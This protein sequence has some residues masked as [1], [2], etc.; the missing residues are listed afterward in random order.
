M[1]HEVIKSVGTRAY[2]Y[3]VESYRDPLTK[4][5]RSRWTYLG[6]VL[7]EN[8]GGERA[9][10]RR[11]P[12]Q[13]RERLLDAFERLAERGPASSISAGA[14][15]LEAGLAH[16]TFYRHFADKR[17]ILRAALDRVREQLERASPTFAPPYGSLEQERARIRA[18]LGAK[19]EAIPARAGLLRAWLEVLE[20]DPVE[21]ERRVRRRRA[22][23][24]ALADYLEA[25]SEL[26][27]IT[28]VRPV[29]LATALIALVDAL[30]RETVTESGGVDA[31][32]VEGIIET[33]D[34]SIFGPVT[35]ASRASPETDSATGKRPES[36]VK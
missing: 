17:T 26:A 6:R 25:L 35:N 12:A 8:G 16:G 34:R 28:G 3:R 20:V 22:L 10:K 15:A 23:V 21:R 19:Y 13:T 7:P 24:T 32:L 9:L 14:V 27:I 18:W 2:R 30:F 29:P 33:F 4:K 36:S 31:T 1:P 11:A 5:V